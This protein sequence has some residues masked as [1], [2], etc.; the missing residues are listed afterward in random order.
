MNDPNDKALWVNNAEKEAEFVNIYGKQLNLILNPAKLVDPYAAD[1]YN[2]EYETLADLKVQAEPFRSSGT[3]YGIPPERCVT[4]N[5]IDVVRY[6]A[7]HDGRRFII[8]FWLCHPESPHNG[9]YGV[10][11]PTLYKDIHN[12][13]RAIHSYQTRDGKNGNKKDSFVLDVTVFKRLAGS[14]LEP[15]NQ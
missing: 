12:L 1:L 6:G 11:L 10:K 13:R 9:V 2:W 14:P 7:L 4:L 8:Y 3:T 5:V 15:P